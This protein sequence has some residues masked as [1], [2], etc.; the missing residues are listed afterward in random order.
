MPSQSPQTPLAVFVYGTLQPGEHYY[1]VLNLAPWVESATPAQVRGQLYALPAGYPALT[2]GKN[3][4]RG[5]LLRFRSAALLPRLDDL[6]GYV[7]DRDRSLNLY[8]R[9]WETIYDQ[10]GQPLEEA[11]LYRMAIAEV[12]RQRGIE[13]PS[14]HWTAAVQAEL[15]GPRVEH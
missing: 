6:E 5:V 1:Q 3:W 8:E 7:P 13:V 14:G 2:E 4:I 10:M 12:T 11:W 15:W 9:C